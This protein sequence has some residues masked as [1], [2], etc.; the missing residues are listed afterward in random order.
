MLEPLLG[1]TNAER[2]LLFIQARGEGYASEIASFFKTNLFGIQR[3]L[4]KQEAG[5][6][7]KSR[8]VGRTRLYTF[9]TRCPYINEL[10]ML[11]EKTLD[12][13]PPDLKDML[14]VNRRRPRRRG[15]PL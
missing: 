5:G 1:S 2:T 12:F 10:N 7:L 8:K 15:K 14:L 13:Y 11:L 3:Q 6:I 9:N 4:D